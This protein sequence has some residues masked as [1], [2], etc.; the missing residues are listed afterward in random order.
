MATTM[1]TVTTTATPAA[2]D[3]QNM[4]PTPGRSTLHHSCPPPALCMVSTALSLVS[5]NSPTDMQPTQWADLHMNSSKVPSSSLPNQ[6]AYIPL[7][8]STV[9]QLTYLLPTVV[10]SPAMLSLLPMRRWMPM[11]NQIRQARCLARLAFLMPP[12]KCPPSSQTMAGPHNACRLMSDLIRNAKK[13][14]TEKWVD[15]HRHFHIRVWLD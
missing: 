3:S 2:V 15:D 8:P 1:F 4:C 6:P 12:H 14:S 7:I 9:A 5:M 10:P 13:K 11:T